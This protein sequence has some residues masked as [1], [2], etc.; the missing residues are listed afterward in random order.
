MELATLSEFRFVPEWRGNREARPQDQGSC[1][2]L[3]FTGIDVLIVYDDADMNAWREERA[4]SVQDPHVLKL[5]PYID[6]DA[7]RALRTL[8]DHTK[9]WAGWTNRGKAVTDGVEVVLS[10]FPGQGWGDVMKP[11]TDCE[12]GDAAAQLKLP[13]S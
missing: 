13:K 8:D 7:L 9:E 4:K 12:E 5:F 11:C 10:G 6:M 2:L 3:P 1:I